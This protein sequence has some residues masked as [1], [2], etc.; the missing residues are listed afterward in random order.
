MG[1][2]DGAAACSC[3]EAHPRQLGRRRL[4]AGERRARPELR[5]VGRVHEAG[6]GV[7]STP[8]ERLAELG[9]SLPTVAKPLASYLPA[10]RT[11]NLVYTSGQLPTIDG[12]LVA[13][14]KVG[15]GSD[16]NVSTDD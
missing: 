3:D 2:R 15:T 14:G 1:V 11:G 7:V 4:G 8:D 16:A 5:A 9:L 6:Q 10:V 13:T 12:K